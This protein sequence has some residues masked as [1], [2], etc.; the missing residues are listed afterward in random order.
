MKK[1]F[2]KF[3]LFCLPVFL[4][5]CILEYGARSMN[6]IYKQKVEFLKDSADVVEV[7]VL[8]TSHANAGVNP[9][10]LDFNTLNM[11]MSSQSL[12][13]DIEVT[14]KYMSRLKNLK[15]VLISVDYHSLYFTME[16][17]RTFFY[18]YY[19]DINYKSKKFNKYNFSI[20][21]DGY[22]VKVGLPL[23]L[24][25]QNWKATKLENRGFGAGIGN[26]KNELTDASAL[27]RLKQ[28]NIAIN[29][30]MKYHQEILNSLSLF[31]KYLQLHNI[32][33]ILLTLPCHQIFNKY[34][35]KNILKTNK[36]DVK[37]LSEKYNIPYLNYTYLN[38]S[39]S[40]FYN[41]DHLNISGAK[42]MTLQINQFLKS[43][44]TKNS[45]NN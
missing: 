16:E 14:K 30:D 21:F 13:F 23:L 17:E 40:L 12:Y 38:L 19:F 3:L 7:L 5:L 35:D 24:N 8:G 1:I 34:A 41:W 28:L 9:Q 4:L 43:Y 2:I 37:F 36:Q 20:F 39:D 26:N 6:S 45:P 44:E 42:I 29:K 22:G 33:P 11:A 15:Y 18:A 25:S 31:I 10:H 27:K 32:K